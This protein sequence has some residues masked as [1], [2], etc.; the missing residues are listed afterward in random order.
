MQKMK[1]LI[2]A[3]DV[4]NDDVALKYVD[5]LRH[6]V[7]IF[8]VGPYLFMKYGR[9]IIRRIQWRRKK[10]FL[11]LKFHD[12]PNTV[13]SAVRAASDMGVY[14][15]SVH[16]SGGRDVLERVLSL[17]KRPQIW[18]I[19]MLTSIDERSYREMGFKDSI[20]DQVI[21]LARMGASCGIEGIVCSPA[22]VALLKKH[23]DIGGRGIKLITPGIRLQSAVSRDDQK[24]FASPYQAR[25]QGADYI[26]VGRPILESPVP[27]RTAASI[28]AELRKVIPL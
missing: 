26:V 5:R 28:N 25:L 16:L 24:R 3:L 21:R 14:A 12:I 18:G 9:R 20:V 4:Q 17:E 22:E 1:P 13:E 27:E 7:D 11:D 6:H 8:K 19:S 2:S 10:I 15:V 23:K